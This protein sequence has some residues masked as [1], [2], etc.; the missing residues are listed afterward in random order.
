MW[1]WRWTAFLLHHFQQLAFSLDNRRLLLMCVA[2]T[3][4]FAA[5]FRGT[6][7]EKGLRKS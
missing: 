6:L 5:K 7:L 2:F 4:H 1:N 3:T